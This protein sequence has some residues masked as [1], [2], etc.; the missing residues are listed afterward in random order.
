MERIAYPSDISDQEWGFMA[1]YLTLMTEEAPQRD[2]KHLPETLIGP[3]FLAFAI[4][5]AKP[6]VETMLIGHSS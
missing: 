3:R 6:V 1:P 5:M 2:Y 4:L